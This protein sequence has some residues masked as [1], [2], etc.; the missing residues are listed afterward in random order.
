[1]GIP[2]RDSTL[3]R[4]AEWLERVE[5]SADGWCH[6][7]LAAAWAVM[8]LIATGHRNA[9]STQRGVQYLLDS[10]QPN[11]GW[12]IPVIRARPDGKRINPYVTAR[13]SVASTTYP[14]MALACYVRQTGGL[15]S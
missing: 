2:R 9:E 3:A 11:G 13:T 15:V 7:P 6:D 14:V 1:M 8:C 5:Q 4:A 12:S 10:Q